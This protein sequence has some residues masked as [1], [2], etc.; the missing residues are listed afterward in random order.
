MSLVALTIFYLSQIEDS[1]N[2][3]LTVDVTSALEVLPVVTES[4]VTLMD[5]DDDNIVL[6]YDDSS[7]DE[8][9]DMDRPVVEEEK[10]DIVGVLAHKSYFL[11]LRDG[12]YYHFPSDKIYELIR[13]RP[14]LGS[15]IW[16]HKS[17]S[18]YEKAEVAPLLGDDFVL[19]FNSGKL[20]FGNARVDRYKGVDLMALRQ[21]FKPTKPLA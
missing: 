20:Y 7:A 11:Q 9:V 19:H 5:N 18:I 2:E 10:S 4:E 6:N 3:Q 14:E 17:D 8:D 21:E 15:L 1:I 16:R 13:E 12:S